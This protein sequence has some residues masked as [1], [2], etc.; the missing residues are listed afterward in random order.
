[1]KTELGVDGWMYRFLDHVAN[2]F[3]S[4][5]KKELFFFKKSLEICANY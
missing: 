5:I 1:M 2:V 3:L 4:N